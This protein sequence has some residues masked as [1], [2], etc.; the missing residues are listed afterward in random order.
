[1]LRRNMIF[2]LQLRNVT[3][4]LFSNK[5]LNLKTSK[6]VVLFYNFRLWKCINLIKKHVY[7]NINY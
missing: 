3:D 1:M 5:M 4:I 6:T 7:M 2:E